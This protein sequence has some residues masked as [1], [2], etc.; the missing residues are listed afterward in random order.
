MTPMRSLTLKLTLAFL[1]VALLGAMLVA[2]FVSARLQAEFN[3]FVLNRIQNDFITT[4]AD[5]Y[6]SNQSWNNIANVV[7]HNLRIKRRLPGGAPN[8]FVLADARGEVIIGDPRHPVGSQLNRVE[9]GRSVPVSVNDKVVGR[10]LFTDGAW[11]LRL[12]QSLE[13]QFLAQMR[14]ATILGA[15]GATLIALVFGAF[16]AYTITRPV[17]ELK[18]GTEMIARGRLGYQVDVRSKDEI[19]NLAESFNQMSIELAHASKMRRQMTADIAH[20][21]RTPLSVILGYAEALH[22]GKLQGT[23]DIYGILHSEALHLQHLID[24]LRTLSLADA[25]ELSL[26]IRPTDV[27]ALL[28]RVAAAYRPAAAE[29]SINIQVETAPVLP[30]VRMDAE[31]MMQVLGNLVSNA[32][33]HTPAGGMIRLI[34]TTD[35]QSLRLRV[36]DTGT[37]IPPEA[38]PFVFARFYR[39]DL[40]RRVDEGESG[41]GLAIAKSLVELQQGSISVSS[42]L[43][44]GTVFEIQLPLDSA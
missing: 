22:D 40:S 38:L 42:E 21:L 26:D 16:L 33:R 8:P 9:R 23:P 30:A 37:G 28:Q 6:E 43:G 44:K 34:A 24:D 20:D 2:G 11:M 36:Q 18:T 27:S 39:V 3:R 1:L 35:A 17:R 12:P 25:G 32:L 29:K 4:L 13:A 19:G 31:R 15:L 10:V 14:R 41:L 5:Y 7:A